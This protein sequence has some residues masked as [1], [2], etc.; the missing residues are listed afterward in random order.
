MI[1]PLFF[2]T[3]MAQKQDNSD[4]SSVESWSPTIKSRWRFS[5][6]ELRV[7]EN[8]YQHES[9]PR[10]DTAD[11]LAHLLQCPKKTVTTWFQNRRAKQKR[12]Q[13][14]Q[15][16]EQAS[17]TQQTQAMIVC[18]DPWIGDETMHLL[19]DGSH[20]QM[21]HQVQPQPGQQQE[22]CQCYYCPIH[23]QYGYGVPVPVGNANWPQEAYCYCT[24]ADDDVEDAQFQL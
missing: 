24:I 10:Q 4:N 23:A 5:V 14:Q 15:K 19:A 1:H 6:D 3:E 8:A 20:Q 18:H 2:P 22:P 12:Q 21:G 13:Q 9:N 7:L 11:R 16:R 17:S